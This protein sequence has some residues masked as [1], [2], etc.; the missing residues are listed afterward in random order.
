VNLALLPKIDLLV[1]DHILGYELVRLGYLKSYTEAPS[2]KKIKEL[3][4]AAQR[5]P[6][7]VPKEAIDDPP[8]S[9]EVTLHSIASR[10]VAPA[11]QFSLNIALVMNAVVPKI[12]MEGHLF[13]LRQT[14]LQPYQFWQAQFGPFNFASRIPSLAISI[15]ALRVANID[16][17]SEKINL[18]DLR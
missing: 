13:S 18:E 7:L 10:S 16:W 9:S 6:V 3:T 12:N 2:L 15:A 5:R 14:L 4:A 8:S 17:A 1:A 11:P